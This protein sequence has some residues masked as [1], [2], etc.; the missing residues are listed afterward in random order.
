MAD[1]EQ[2]GPMKCLFCGGSSESA[3]NGGKIIS[4]ADVSAHQYCLVRSTRQA[5]HAAIVLI[6]LS[7]PPVFFLWSGSAGKRG[8][9]RGIERISVSR[10]L[11]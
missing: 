6:T 11:R 1:A 5:S 8:E 7:S 2:S 4:K 9:G 10:C 3:E